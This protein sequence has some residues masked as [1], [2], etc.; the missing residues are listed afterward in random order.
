MEFIDKI[1]EHISQG[2]TEKAIKLLVEFTKENKPDMHD[3]AVLLS[4]QFRQWKREVSLGVQQ[5]NSELRRIE[6]GII[7]LLTDESISDN[8][9]ADLNLSRQKFN[10]QPP[11]KKS[12][13]LPIALGVLSLVVVF[14]AWQMMTH[15]DQSHATTV[16]EFSE[17]GNEGMSEH[18]AIL[19]EANS[20][21][22][23]AGNEGVSENLNNANEAGNEGSNEI[24]GQPV[25]TSSDNQADT[26]V[27]WDN[28]N[29]I[30]FG[31][32]DAGIEGYFQYNGNYEWAELDAAKNY[33]FTFEE[34]HRDDWSVYILD[35]SR[36]M[37][38]E[39]DLYTNQINLSS[40]DG[41]LRML[42]FVK[43]KE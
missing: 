43:T 17:A 14:M 23:E 36:D 15:N 42:Y 10:A 40:A 12:K 32:Q 35:E 7:N 24:T 8:S 2:E 18:A 21:R 3:E 11:A 33:R 41:P 38:I 22:N 26:G 29:L 39:I 28:I 13:L 20:N 34:T 9:L 6:M 16:P 1:K 27:D 31:G 19:D 37:E 4:G 5:S 30:G 25:S